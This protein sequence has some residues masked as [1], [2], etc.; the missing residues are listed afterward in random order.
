LADPTHNP[1]SFS[2]GQAP[3]VDR[4]TL[5]QARRRAKGRRWPK[6]LA[7][8]LVVLVVLTGAAAAGVIGYGRHLYDEIKKVKAPHLHTQP[9]PGQPFNILMVGSDSRS[10]VKTT[11]KQKIEFGGTGTTVGGQRSDVTMV[12]RFIPATKQIWVLSIPRDLW[13]TI[14]GDGPIHGMTRINSSF[15]TGPDLLIQTIETDLGIQVNHF[16][17][18]T[19]QGFQNMVDALGGITMDFPTEVKDAY[20]GLDVTQTG[21]QLVD[22]ATALELVRARHLYYMTHGEW[23]YDGLSDFSRI[24]RQDAFFRSLLQK[25]NSVKYDPFT[26]KNF[27]QA[28]VKNLTIDTT[29]SE[30]DLI[31]LATTFHGIPS[32]NLHTETLPTTSFTSPAGADVLNEA[33]PYAKDMIEAFNKLGVTTAPATASPGGAKP[34]KPAQTTTTT[35]A[36]LPPSQVQVEVLNG[37]NFTQPVASQTSAKLKEAGFG[38]SGIGNAT[39]HVTTTEIEYAE[40]HLAAAQTVQIHLSGKTELVA[41]PQLQGD[42]VILTVGTSL[43]AVTGLGGATGSSATGSSGTGAAATASGGTGAGGPTTTTTVPPPPD[44]YTNT[45]PEPWNPTPCTL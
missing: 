42:R 1:D 16:I 18:V 19:F 44:V 41:D 26:V 11:P 43:S 3:G 4:R 2:L 39:S 30:S 38:I 10:F 27:L 14:P 22:G 32:A 37:V 15:N 8:G 9:P 45:Q 31:S 40:G 13:V 5:Q 12:A 20:S 23:L 6:R 35:S 21:C 36:T 34:A 17:S 24:Q 25:V 7:I 33:Q 29:L 28:A